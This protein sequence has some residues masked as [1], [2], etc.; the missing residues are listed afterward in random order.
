M[1]TTKQ[2]THILTHLRHV[3]RQSIKGGRCSALNQYYKST[4]SDEVFNDISN[5]NGKICEILD[6]YF[7]YT[8]KHRKTIQNEYNLETIEISI[9]KEEPNILIKNLTN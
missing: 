8:N 4:I 7:Q 1:E 6:K 5:I 2:F 9:K 3:V